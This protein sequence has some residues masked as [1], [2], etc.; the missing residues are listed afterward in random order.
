MFEFINQPGLTEFLSELKDIKMN[1]LK[2][3]QGMVRNMNLPGKNF[4]FISTASGD[5]FFHW[6]E[7]QN[8]SDKPFHHL[9]IGD[10]ITFV[11]ATSSEGKP[12]AQ[13]VEFKYLVDTR[14]KKN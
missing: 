4:G 1:E 7:Y 8:T 10:P 9:R 6:S 2:R 3:E 12:I 13:A 5:R 11:A 14:K